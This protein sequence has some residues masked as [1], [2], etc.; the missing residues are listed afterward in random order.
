MQSPP[1]RA[2]SK[3]WGVRRTVCIVVGRKQPDLRKFSGAVVLS[4]RRPNCLNYL[5]GHLQPCHQ[6]HERS[7]GLEQHQHLKKRVVD[8]VE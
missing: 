2:R 3:D 6:G 7:H 5:S 1:P 8:V 4:L